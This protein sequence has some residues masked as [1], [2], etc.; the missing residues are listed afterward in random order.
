MESKQSGDWL[1]GHKEHIGKDCQQ[2]QNEASHSSSLVNLPHNHDV[3]VVKLEDIIASLPKSLRESFEPLID[4]HN[5]A[6]A[7]ASAAIP[8]TILANFAHGSSQMYRP[9]DGVE[10]QKTADGTYTTV[11]HDDET[12]KIT[13]QV[14]LEKGSA[15]SE[16]A[17][18]AFAIASVAVG[19]AQMMNI[20]SQLADIN[21]TLT[22]IESF[23]Y[24]K[25]VNAVK[26]AIWAIGDIDFSSPIEGESRVVACREKIDE[27]CRNLLVVMEN[28]V[29]NMPDVKQP[30]FFE[31]WLLRERDTA[32]VRAEESFKRILA[33]LQSYLVGMLYL[34]ATDGF[35]HGSRH[36]SRNRLANELLELTQ[37]VRLSEKVRMVPMLT[38]KLNPEKFV[39]EL[40]SRTEQLKVSAAPENNGKGNDRLI[41]PC[42][43]SKKKVE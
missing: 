9:V 1:N 39:N 43:P 21:R 23:L 34:I 16:A 15:F 40:V 8:Q 30:S 33:V 11:L 6:I 14:K 17:T 3:S 42:S 7:A 31:G 12:G 28:E 5:S 24:M 35:V 27:A 20:A 32:P 4:L 22:N 37:R 19:Q 13:K 2:E 10:L 41:I 36:D 18:T 25:E 29:E 26:S 38:C